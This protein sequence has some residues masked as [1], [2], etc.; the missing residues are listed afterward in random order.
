MEAAMIPTHT[1]T[2]AALRRLERTIVAPLTAY[3]LVTEPTATARAL[4]EL[5]AEVGRTPEALTRKALP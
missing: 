4:A 2:A 3:K 5:S 1:A